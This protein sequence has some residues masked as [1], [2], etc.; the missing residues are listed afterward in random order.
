MVLRM[1]FE[2]RRT[3][4]DKNKS[5]T[6]IAVFIAVNAMKTFLTVQKLNATV[7]HALKLFRKTHFQSPACCVHVG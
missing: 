2:T 1:N 7:S 3:S 5:S 6:G 4:D